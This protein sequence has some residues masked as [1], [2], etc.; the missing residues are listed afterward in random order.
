MFSF[1][2]SPS[3]SRSQYTL[4]ETQNEKNAQW[5]ATILVRDWLLDFLKNPT[6]KQEFCDGIV[7]LGIS[8]ITISGSKVGKW[9]T[10]IGC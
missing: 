6:I 1:H 9:V 2:S 4:F 3:F 8:T 7:H 5:V 10:V